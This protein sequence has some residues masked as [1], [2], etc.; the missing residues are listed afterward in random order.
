[1]LVVIIFSC[2]QKQ[3]NYKTIKGRWWYVEET[4]YKEIHASDSCIYIFDFSNYSDRCYELEYVIR[5]DT[6]W[7]IPPQK[8]F[9]AI[10]IEPYFR[11]SVV[12]FETDS[13]ILVKNSK[14]IVY[15]KLDDV[16][17]IYSKHLPQVFKNEKLD[18][19]AWERWLKY[20]DK[21]DQRAIRFHNDYRESKYKGDKN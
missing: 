3:D 6:F 17:D 18:S 15:H 16:E 12:K 14:E 5:N 8:R 1:M 13:F 21:Y 4:I 19:V 9:S 2:N 10:K 20:Q 7:T 11:G